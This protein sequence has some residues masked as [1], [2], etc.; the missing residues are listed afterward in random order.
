LRRWCFFL[1]QQCQLT[2][3]ASGGRNPACFTAFNAARHS[4]SVH[5]TESL[6]DFDRRDV[7]GRRVPRYPGLL[8]YPSASSPASAM[9]P[10]PGW[11]PRESGCK[12]G[13]RTQVAFYVLC[14]GLFDLAVFGRQA[15]RKWMSAAQQEGRDMRRRGARAFRGDP[16]CLAHPWHTSNE[17]EKVETDPLAS[18]A[19]AHHLLP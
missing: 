19:V 7:L 5:R 14:P 6:D 10:P 13:T 17:S 4:A 2:S 18:E 12:R 1:P 16:S 3:A 9:R 8:A 15:A 11:M